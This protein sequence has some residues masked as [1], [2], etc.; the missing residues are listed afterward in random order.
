ML[1][2]ITQNFVYYDKN[3][4]R[5]QRFGAKKSKVPGKMTIQMQQKP[6][7]VVQE[8]NSVDKCNVPFCLIS[9]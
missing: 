6:Q 4:L 5:I 7:K 9:Y 8:C 1:T 3:C 2:T